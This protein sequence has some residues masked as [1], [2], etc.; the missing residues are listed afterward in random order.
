MLHVNKLDLEKV[1]LQSVARLNPTLTIPMLD[2]VL[3]MRIF[4]KRKFAYKVQLTSTW[5]TTKTAATSLIIKKYKIELIRNVA[6]SNKIALLAQKISLDHR[7][8]PTVLVVMTLL[9]S[10]K[11]HV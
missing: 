5:E 7:K 4:Q 11:L 3:L 2:L 8:L 10:Y 9:C 1:L 6:V